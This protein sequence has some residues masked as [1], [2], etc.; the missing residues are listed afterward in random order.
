MFDLPVAAEIVVLDDGSTDGSA[1]FLSGQND[2]RVRLM[3]R[4]GLG[5][6]RAR[7]AA[8]LAA[9]GKHL[10]FLDAHMDLPAGWWRPLLTLLSRQSAGAVQPCITDV[11]ARNAKG[12]GERFRGADLTLEW[13]PKRRLSPY[14]VPIL[15]GCCF[16]VR[17]AVFLTL[18]GLDGGMVGWG[19]EDCEFSL[20]LWRL[21]YEIWIDPNTEV[22]HRFRTSAPYIIDWGV[23]LHNRLRTA[24]A[25]FSLTRLERIVSSLQ[26][27][28]QF[29]VA[30][31]AV[32]RSDIWR[33]RQWHQRYSIRDDDWFLNQSGLVF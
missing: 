1:E 24:C 33:L 30:H 10:I 12:Y 18:G 9:S 26:D 32:M 22:G 4:P 20:R 2:N 11:T 6:A 15:C 25:H 16:A 7:N 3:R 19:S 23:V 5:V 8:A 17:R 13:L 14:P 28:P 31:A 27:L 29:A 21:G